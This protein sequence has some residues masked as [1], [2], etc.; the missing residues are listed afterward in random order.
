MILKSKGIKKVDPIKAA[1]EKKKKIN[2]VKPK[3]DDYAAFVKAENHAYNQLRKRTIQKIKLDKE[4]IKKAA[5]SLIKYHSGSKKQ[6]DLLDQDDDFIYIEIVLSKV[7]EEFSIRPLQIALPVPI[8]GAEQ[9]TKFC[10]FTKDP[11]REYKDKVKNLEI[12]TV[13]RIMGY[14]KIDKKFPTYKDKL[15]LFYSYDLFFVDYTIYDLIRK[16][17]GKIFYERKKIP[18]P[19]NCKEVPAGQKEQHGEDYQAYLND[20]AN[21]TYFS[22]GNGPVYTIKIARTNMNIKDIVKNVIHGTYNTVP[23]LLK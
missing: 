13:A 18:S 19:I 9:G 3:I 22:M 23:H 7:P 8:Y 14:S 20:L 6:N 10:I 2:T 15:K 17:T 16:P 1:E 4:L 12:P 5:K 21:Y 11:Q